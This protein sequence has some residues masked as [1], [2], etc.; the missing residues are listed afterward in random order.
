[1]RLRLRSFHSFLREALPA[2]PARLLEIGCGDGALAIALTGD[3]YDVTAIDPHAPEGAMFHRV[4]LEDYE[5]EAGSFDAVVAS[6]ALHHV[7][8]LDAGTATIERL[9]APGGR[10]VLAEF[11]KER[12]AGTTARWYHG[13]RGAL[14]AAGYEDAVID[15]DFDAWHRQWTQDRADVH[16]SSD[17]LAALS[18]RF[19]EFRLEWVPYL[20]SYRLDDSLEPAERAVID[21]GEIEAVGLHYVGE[22]R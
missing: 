15:P 7:P 9:L 2:P 22:R 18:R 8:D 14:A 13:Q 6:V 11:A 16:P 5:G 21:S 20:Y 4:R 19:V 1:M 10:L 17:L 12:I 3:G